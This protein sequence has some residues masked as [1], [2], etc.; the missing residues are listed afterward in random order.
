M[1]W[2]SLR[3]FYWL[4]PRALLSKNSGKSSDPESAEGPQNAPQLMGLLWGITTVI[5]V[6]WSLLDTARRYLSGEQIS[7]G[8]WLRPI[9]I[10][11]IALGLIG[12]ASF[13]VVAVLSLMLA[14]VHWHSW[15]ARVPATVTRRAG[16]VR[17]RLAEL[18]EL[19]TNIPEHAAS[20]ERDRL[21]AKRAELEA[22]AAELQD[23]RKILGRL[24]IRSD[25]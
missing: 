9:Y 18:A 16:D 4:T 11:E 25:A 5:M 23:V 17:K 15:R 7:A 3:S 10:G 6:L 8:Y 21:A 1:R 2:H 12:L 24:G 22:E 19:E 14:K 20:E 13:A